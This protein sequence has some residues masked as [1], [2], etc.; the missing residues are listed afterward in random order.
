M[1]EVGSKQGRWVTRREGEGF[2]S[3]PRRGKKRGRESE[4][5]DGREQR[6]AFFLPFSKS[7]LALFF[8]FRFLF[9]LRRL[10]FKPWKTSRTSRSP[11]M[12]NSLG[13]ETWARAEA[14]AAVAESAA[15]RAGFVRFSRAGRRSPA[16]AL[17]A[18][19]TAAAAADDTL[20]T[21]TRFVQ[22]R[23]LR[24]RRVRR[25][26]PARL[27]PHLRLRPQ[28]RGQRDDGRGPQGGGLRG[29]G[30]GRADGGGPA[31]KT[32][33]KTKSSSAS[34]DAWV[35]NSCT[36]KGP[37][38]AAVEKLVAQ[39]KARGET[40]RRRGLRAAGRAAI[41]NL[42]GRVAARRQAARQ[43]RRRRLRSPERKRREADA[44]V[45]GSCRR[46]TCRGC[47]GTRT[48]RSFP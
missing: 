14:A 36:V 3:R 41:E 2:P 40:D 33:P 39:A 31:T 47:G 44:A 20:S 9:L 37:S 21:P 38:Q 26:H 13:E 25:R 5:K 34:A 46:W 28:R 29:Q 23:Q 15:A 19:D 45:R 22:A 16:P 8:T 48:S 6:R 32:K 27:A 1:K 10:L 11:P 30:R 4:G 35:V 17:A 18:D 7:N 42:G 12:R 24:P 43:S